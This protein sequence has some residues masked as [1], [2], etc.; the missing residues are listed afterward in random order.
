MSAL[1]R[2]KL[3]TNALKI[4]EV[5]TNLYWVGKQ[6]GADKLSLDALEQILRSTRGFTVLD[7]RQ[8]SL[9]PGED[10]DIY[11]KSIEESPEPDKKGRTPETVTLGSNWED[12]P[13]TDGHKS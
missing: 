4:A 7:D 11:L 3:L 6:E 2:R 9:S 5:Q 12:T 1:S 8:K 10:S 13:E